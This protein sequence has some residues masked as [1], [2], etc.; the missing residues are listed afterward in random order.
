M[1]FKRPAALRL[2]S[3]EEMERVEALFPRGD[4]EKVLGDA[5]VEQV[6]GRD[7]EGEEAAGVKAPA[8]SWPGVLAASA[9]ENVGWEGVNKAF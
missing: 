5:V 3:G 7:G 8:A 2:T 6:L 1:D 9:R 4:I